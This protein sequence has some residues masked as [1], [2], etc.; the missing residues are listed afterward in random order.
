MRVIPRSWKGDLRCGAGWFQSRVPWLRDW[1]RMVLSMAS[2]ME[3]SE[4]LTR[5]AAARNRSHR[6]SRR[7][8]ARRGGRRRHYHVP[9]PQEPPQGSASAGSRRRAVRQGCSGS[10]GL[11]I[12]TPTR[13]TAG[14]DGRVSRSQAGSSNSPACDL[15]VCPSHRPRLRPDAG[16]SPNSRPRQNCRKSMSD[17]GN[18][19][20][21]HGL[22]T[23][24]KSIRLRT[25]SGQINRTNCHLCG[26][27]PTY[28]SRNTPPL[29]S[30]SRILLFCCYTTT[31][32]LLVCCNR[33]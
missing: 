5:A 26:E 32:P 24:P 21:N 27:S 15:L 10:G 6:R 33:H 9:E 12:H 28:I 17:S 30:V 3:D 31:H 20:I 2:G 8:V 29:T 16:T 14:R 4:R 1:R 22:F 19:K 11:R 7:E 13:A 23:P 25:N 18:F